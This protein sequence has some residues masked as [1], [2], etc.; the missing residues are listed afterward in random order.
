MLDSVFDTSLNSRGYMGKGLYI[1]VLCYGRV[2]KEIT[3]VNKLNQRHIHG[4]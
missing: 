1:R 2:E 3:K 4:I